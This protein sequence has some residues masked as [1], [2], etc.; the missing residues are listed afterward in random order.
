MPRKTLVLIVAA[1][2]ALTL[3]VGVGYVLGV[4]AVMQ[5]VCR[6]PV[7][8][9]GPQPKGIPYPSTICEDCFERYPDWW[10]YLGGCPW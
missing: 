2:L 10:C 5:E 6:A 3:A 8:V 4:R 1:I 7:P 9:E